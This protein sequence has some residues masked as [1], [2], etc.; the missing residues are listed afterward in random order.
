GTELE[1]ANRPNDPIYFLNLF[2][3][4]REVDLDLYNLENNY[5]GDIY[6][7]TVE[8][9]EGTQTYYIAANDNGSI[10]EIIQTIVSIQENLPGASFSPFAS[11]DVVP[12]S[13]PIPDPSTS[14]PATSPVPGA[15]PGN[16]GE[17]NDSPFTCDFNESG[18]N[19]KPYRVS[20][21][22]CSNEPSPVP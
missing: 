20:N 5:V 14:T 16:G 9:D 10:N 22:V 12:T 4:I 7:I 13:S 15:T 8:T 17:Y 21:V 1:Y 18:S 2:R 11:P 3:V 6:K 19:I